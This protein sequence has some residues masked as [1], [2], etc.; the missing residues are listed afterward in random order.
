MYGQN[1]KGE[2]LQLGKRQGRGGKAQTNLA[3]K[4]F[5]TIRTA[6]W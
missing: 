1:L 3:T 5:F 6:V 2:S 4:T